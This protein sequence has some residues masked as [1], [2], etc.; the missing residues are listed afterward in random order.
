M[1][2]QMKIKQ[3]TNCNAYICKKAQEANEQ[4]SF[5]GYRTIKHVYTAITKSS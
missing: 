5:F 3:S 4:T 2:K 1:I